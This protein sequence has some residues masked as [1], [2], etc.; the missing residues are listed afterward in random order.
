LK[1]ERSKTH[2]KG[3]KDTK[4][5]TKERFTAEGAEGAERKSREE[6]KEKE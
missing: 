3:T 5:A 2:H 4:T 1:G 6:R